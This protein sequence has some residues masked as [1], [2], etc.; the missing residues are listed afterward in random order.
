ML[1]VAAAFFRYL[2]VLRGVVE[3]DRRRVAVVARADLKAGALVFVV[4]A[5]L[6]VCCQRGRY[7]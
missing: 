6:L 7:D 5:V 2:A 4:Q 3:A 1:Q